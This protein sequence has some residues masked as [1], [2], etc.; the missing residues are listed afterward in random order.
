MQNNETKQADPD[1]FWKKGNM[2]VRLRR[3]IML[4]LPEPAS[5][6]NPRPH[7]YAAPATLSVAGWS[8]D[9]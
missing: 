5:L 3:T 4:P 8:E 2:I 1:S 9:L 7:R 6:T